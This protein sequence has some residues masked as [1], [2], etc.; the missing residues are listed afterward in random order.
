MALIVGFQH[1]ARKAMAELDIRA[2]YM[3]ALTDRL[4]GGLREHI[5]DLRMNTVLDRSAPHIVNVSFMDADH[6]DGEAILQAMDMRG[7]AVS[8][9]SA[10]V[11]GS[12]QASHVLLAMGRSPSESKA[13]VRFSVCNRTTVQDVEEAIAIMSDVIRNMRVATH[14]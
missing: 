13:A 12:L 2:H 9:G 3:R 11:S 6:L 7:I 8:N 5:P 10:C 4:A 1:A 14:I